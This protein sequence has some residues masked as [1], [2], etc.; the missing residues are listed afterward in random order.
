[1]SI[2]GPFDIKIFFKYIKT[3]RD[4]NHDLKNV[5]VCIHL[6]KI[7]NLI[8]LSS[9]KCGNGRKLYGFLTWTIRGLSNSFWTFL[10]QTN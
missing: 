3:V 4:T 8:F 9:S 6:K 5:L 7:K 10:F 1:M 2:L